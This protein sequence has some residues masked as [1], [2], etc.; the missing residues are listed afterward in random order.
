[1]HFLSVCCDIICPEINKHSN[2]RMWV[3]FV[4]STN[5]KSCWKSTQSTSCTIFKFS[6]LCGAPCRLAPKGMSPLP[7]HVLH[8]WSPPML[9]SLLYVFPSECWFSSSV[10][11]FFWQFAHFCVT[12]HSPAW[13]SSSSWPVVSREG[14][15]ELLMGRGAGARPLAWALSAACGY[16]AFQPVRIF[17]ASTWD[18]ASVDCCLVQAGWGG[19]YVRT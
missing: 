18:C 2:S 13:G 4:Y 12:V 3:C 6:G 17:T 1:M 10:W 9:F 11:W 5:L 15:D 7:P 14:K 19:Q 8:P 16:P